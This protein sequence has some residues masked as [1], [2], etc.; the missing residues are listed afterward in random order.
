MVGPDTCVSLLIQPT[1]PLSFLELWFRLIYVIETSPRCH[2][3]LPPKNSP[4]QKASMTQSTFLIMLIPV[5]FPLATEGQRL[6]TDAIE[7][8]AVKATGTGALSP[9]TSS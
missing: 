5:A 4:R 8:V 7:V 3:Q 2:A 9:G 1:P 6:E